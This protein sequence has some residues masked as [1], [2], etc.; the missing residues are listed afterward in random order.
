MMRIKLRLSAYFSGVFTIDYNTTYNVDDHKNEILNKTDL[1]I[2]LSDV[3]FND[4]SIFKALDRLNIGLYI[5]LQVL[6]GYILEFCSKQ[7]M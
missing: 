3:E 7:E 2:F 6:M 4:L 1:E 5:N